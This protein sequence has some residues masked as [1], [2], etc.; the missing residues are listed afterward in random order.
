MSRCCVPVCLVASLFAQPPRIDSI[1]P[2]QG[3]IA[4]GTAVVVRGANFGGAQI[5]LDKNPLAPA[6]A[7]PDEV[8]F[9]APKHDNGYGIV[10]IA[11]PAGTAVARFLYMPPALK[12]LPPGYITTIAGVGRYYGDYGP[13]RE[14]SVGSSRLAYGPDGSIYMTQS[15]QNKKPVSTLFNTQFL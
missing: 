6:S 1:T 4:G 12:D 10:R 8:R 14:A 15:D 5:S 11:T 7:V 9:V 13:A 2:A 3:P